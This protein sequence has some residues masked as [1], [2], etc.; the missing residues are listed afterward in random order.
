[1]GKLLNEKTVV[2]DEKKDLLKLCG[3]Q[4]CME[5]RVVILGMIETIEKTNV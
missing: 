3:R 1:M 2:K 5:V 4:C